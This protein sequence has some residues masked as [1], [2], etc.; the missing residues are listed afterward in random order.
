[1]AVVTRSATADPGL[2]AQ[3]DGSTRTNH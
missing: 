2:S 1:V 3:S